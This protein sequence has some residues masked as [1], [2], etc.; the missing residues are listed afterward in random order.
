MHTTKI[1]GK[2]PDFNVNT[3]I[4][5]CTN[6]TLTHLTNAELNIKFNILFYRLIYLTAYRYFCNCCKSNGAPCY[7]KYIYI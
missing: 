2:T 5:P 7:K 6:S 1:N 3:F 4:H